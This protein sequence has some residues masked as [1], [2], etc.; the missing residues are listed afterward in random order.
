MKSKRRK[1]RRFAFTFTEEFIDRIPL[2]ER[3]RE[4]TIV[5]G[6]TPGPTTTLLPNVFGV[7][8]TEGKY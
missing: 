3:M 5:K 2:P 1:L 4:V 8:K 7:K 6:R